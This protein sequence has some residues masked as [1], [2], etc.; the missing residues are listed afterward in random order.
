MIVQSITLWRVTLPMKFDFQTAKGLVRE[1]HTLVVDVET[2]NGTRGYGEVVAFDTPFYTAETITTSEEWL[3][4]VIPYFVGVK[5]KEPW[6]CYKVL[7]DLIPTAPHAAPM[8][9]AGLENAL[10]HAYFEEEGLPMIRTLLERELQ[11]RTAGGY[12]AGACKTDVREPGVREIAVGETSSCE[13]D[14]CEDFS[15]NDEIPIGLVFGDM[16]IPNL[17]QRIDDA[18]QKGC[19]RIKI[20][21]TPRDAVERLQAV[22]EAYP[23]LILAADAN[24][25]FTIDN[26]PQVA[27]LDRFNLRTIEEPFSLIDDDL[28]KTYG[29]L[30]HD[31]WKEWHTPITF[32]ESI[33]SLDALQA[34]ERCRVAIETIQTTETIQAAKII[35]A[36]ETIPVNEILQATEAASRRFQPVLNIKIGRLGGLRETLRCLAYCQAH[37]WGFWIGSM[38]ESGISKILHVQ[39]AALPDVWMAGDLS[40]SKRYFEEDLISPDISFVDGRMKVPHGPGLGVTVRRDYLQTYGEILKEFV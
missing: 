31:F 38:V 1:R 33:Q 9:W 11:A 21:L 17:L 32:D 13:V 4:Q 19:K 29:A 16:P 20:K 40:D 7:E 15:L 24:R 10:L 18:V 39:L 22:R 12:K 26:W 2:A 5:M 28:V 6:D 35:H 23:D 25:S 3:N 27:Q 36:S 8:A 34:M 14:I 30:P 37:K